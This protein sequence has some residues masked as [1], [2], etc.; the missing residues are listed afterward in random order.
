MIADFSF[1]TKWTIDDINIFLF[2]FSLHPEIKLP[3]ILIAWLST[4]ND[5]FDFNV[6]YKVCQD[7]K[8]P[9]PRNNFSFDKTAYDESGKRFVKRLQDEG[10]NPIDYIVDNN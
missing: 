2:Y 4:E 9:F 5:E 8:L 6:F 7:R 1:I 3:N 10:K